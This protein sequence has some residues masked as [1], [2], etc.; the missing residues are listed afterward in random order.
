MEM[1]PAEPELDS[2]DVQLGPGQ[3]AYL[4]EEV[5]EG[6]PRPTRAVVLLP[7]A[8]GFQGPRIRR[9]ADR[10]AV[11]CFSLVLVPDLH[12]GDP[13]HHSRA[14][15]GNGAFAAWEGSLPPQRIARDLHDW[16]IYL[17]ADH[18]V[19]PVAFA[20]AGLGAEHMLRA[21]GPEG[22][23]LRI[24]TG[25][26]FGARRACREELAGAKAPVLCLFD[27]SNGEA[28]KWARSALE[29][30]FDREPE[31]GTSASKAVVVEAAEPV[32]QSPVM[33]V[34]KLRRLRVAELRERLMALGASTTGKKDELIARLQHLE[35]SPLPATPPPSPLPPSP[36]AVPASSMVMQFGGLD[37]S[38]EEP[39]DAED[40]SACA[41]GAPEE[42]MG[43]LLGCGSDEDDGIIMA[44]AWLN[45]HLDRAS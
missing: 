31:R 36:S 9:L 25:V 23:D 17:R 40:A 6:I 13:W 19:R 7:D 33:S 35:I 39:D 12:H 38:W 1:V 11:F 44:E 37:R 8:T 27:E 41:D 34:S 45:L 5:R 10:I 3:T 24:V 43:S 42:D 14:S 18:R 22:P 26:A 32:K 20:G 28:A 2:R 4:T 29:S 16:T 15:G 30:S 21:L